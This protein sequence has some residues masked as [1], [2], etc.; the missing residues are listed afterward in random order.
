M[1]SCS[2]SVTRATG[3]P[4][5][6]TALALEILLSLRQTVECKAIEIY[7]VPAPTGGLAASVL[8][9]RLRDW[10]DAVELG[11]TGVLCPCCGPW[12]MASPWLGALA[13]QCSVTAATP[14]QRLCH[15]QGQLC[16]CDSGVTFTAHGA[17]CPRQSQCSSA[18]RPHPVKA[19]Q[20]RL[21]ASV[22]REE[23]GI[24]P[25]YN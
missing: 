17:L 22:N 7:R 6:T 9:L 15:G 25:N 18:A 8:V 13:L 21:A 20:L 4:C 5:G 10:R 23:I 2:R 16:P 11:S 12:G 19:G 1:A 24:S 14:E 3:D